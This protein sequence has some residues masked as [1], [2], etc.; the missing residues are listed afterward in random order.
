MPLNAGV[1]LCTNLRGTAPLKFGKAKNVQNSARFRTTSEFDRKY[2][3][4]RFRYQQAVNGVINCRFFSALN[5][6]L[7][8]F[9]SLTTKLCLL[10]SISPTFTVSAFSKNFRF[11]LHISGERIKISINGKRRLQLLSITRRTQQHW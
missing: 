1:N 10:I 2:L 5:K 6:N 11:L 4:K 7:I 9:R 3:W 8:N